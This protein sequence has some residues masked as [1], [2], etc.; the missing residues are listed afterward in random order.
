M[1]SITLPLN[2]DSPYKAGSII[3]FWSR[4]HMTLT[5]YLTL[6]IYNPLS[7]WINRR[8]AAAGKPNSRKATRTLS[9]FS[10]LVALPTLTTMFLAGIWHGAGFQFIVFGVLH[11]I[12]LTINHAWRIFRKENTILARLFAFRPLCV[13]ITFVAVIVG[14]VF[15]RAQSTSD[16]VRLLGG[17]FAWNGSGILS[18]QD[19]PSHA[20]IVFLL[21]PVVWLLPNTQQ[22]LGQARGAPTNV[23]GTR[24]A[25]LW[26]PSWEW[27]VSLGLLLVGALF[28]MTD[29]TSFLYFQF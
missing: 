13:L 14:Q 26:Q 11:G 28:Y 20:F 2:F 16:A 18:T 27:A 24:L 21:L 19:H 15:F 17:L 23:L 10:S 7:M 5:R 1:F 12:Y 8:R 25:L 29:T 4:W 22:I 9:G 6:Y 3:E